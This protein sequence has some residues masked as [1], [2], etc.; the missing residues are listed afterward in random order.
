[1]R[2]RGVPQSSPARNHPRH[3]N[4][5][6]AGVIAADSPQ[7]PVHATVVSSSWEI[8]HEVHPASLQHHDGIGTVLPPREG[9]P[10]DHP[11]TG[12][13]ADVAMD[14]YAVPILLQH[15]ALHH[16]HRDYPRRYYQNGEVHFRKTG[17]QRR[18]R[19]EDFHTVYRTA[20]HVPDRHFKHYLLGKRRNQ[21]PP[22]APPIVT[23]DGLARACLGFSLVAMV[24]LLIIGFLFDAQPLYIKGALPVARYV[25]VS[26]V[27][28][29]SSS[30]S[31][32]ASSSTGGSSTTRYV[33]QYDIPRRGR[34]RR[35]ERL[36][37]ARVSYH[38]AAAYAATALACYYWLHRDRVHVWIRHRTRTLGHHHRYDEIPDGSAGSDGLLLP[39]V[40]H[41]RIGPLHPEPST[42][43][44]AYQIGWGSRL[45][46]GVLQWLA[47]R[48]WAL[49]PVKFRRKREPK[50]V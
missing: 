50:C 47:V 3:H 32:S 30:A 17:N 33:A 23:E 43:T 24:F 44:S 20:H 41:P 25:T 37:P 19:P 6:P 27:K 18:T 10:P 2:Q 38:A 26:S 14:P 12:R 1:M 36:V 34:G 11:V 22:K 42:T 35:P 16:P 40:I 39:T 15:P 28:A 4:H 31:A 48:G 29:S 13:L 21:I 5:P 45:K 46:A 8:S 9:L 7:G 49:R